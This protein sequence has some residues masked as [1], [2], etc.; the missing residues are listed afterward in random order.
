[1]E[2]SQDMATEPKWAALRNTVRLGFLPRLTPCL[3]P[4]NRVAV[5]I[6]ELD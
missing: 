1:M 2:A 6:D 5:E 4:T 3:L